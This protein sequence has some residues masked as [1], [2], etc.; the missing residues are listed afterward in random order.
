MDNRWVMISRRHLT[1]FFAVGITVLIIY[2]LQHRGVIA[3]SEIGAALVAFAIIFIG[4]A[5]WW[6]FK[7][8]IERLVGSSKKSGEQSKITQ[9]EELVKLIKPLY[10]EFDKYRYTEKNGY[11]GLID[12]LVHEK[13]LNFDKEHEE[14]YTLIG[15]DRV[16]FIVDTMQKQ[17]DLAQPELKESIYKYL[18]L[19][20]IQRDGD[21]QYGPREFDAMRDILVRIFDLVEKR[22]KDLMWGKKES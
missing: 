8:D 10:G 18:E 17:G 1:S 11:I 22:Y 14:Y 16:G 9:N 6:G 3:L 19:R 20:Q 7:E 2:T 21:K 12:A 13:W 15:I 5:S 4:G